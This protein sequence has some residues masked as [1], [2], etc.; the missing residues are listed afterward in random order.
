MNKYNVIFFIILFFLNHYQAISKENIVSTESSGKYEQKIASIKT[1]KAN[2][3][4]GPGENFPIKWTYI[5]RH[6]PIILID[7]FDHWKKVK[8][9][10]NS[11]GWMHKS[12]ISQRKTSLV[13]FSDYLRK[14]PKKKS[15]KIALLKKKVIVEIKNCKISWCKIKVVKKNFSGWYIKNYLWKTKLIKIE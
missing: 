11:L 6:W 7:K 1:S 9:F 13:L 12:Q 15:K 5:K 3:R 10:D 2:L 4:Y 14:Y 8:T